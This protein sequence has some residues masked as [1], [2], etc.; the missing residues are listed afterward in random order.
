[1]TR[2]AFESVGRSLVEVASQYGVTV[3]LSKTK[4]LAMMSAS[5][6]DDVCLVEMQGARLEVVSNF[7]YLVS[8]LCHDGEITCEVSCRIA[9]VVRVF[10]CL[11]VPIFLNRSLSISTKRD[12]YE[13]VVLSVLL[14]GAETWTL[15]APSPS[16][17]TLGYNM[18]VFSAF[19]E[20]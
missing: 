8:C 17:H 1:M 11:R 2:A 5:G 9:K 12:V 3:S 7:S 4:G 20:S 19:L 13:A 16:C 18:M 6:E 10:G 14:Y 15:K